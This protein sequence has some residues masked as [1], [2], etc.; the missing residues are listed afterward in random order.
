M[1]SNISSFEVEKSS[2]NKKYLIKSEA[3]DLKRRN[4]ESQHKIVFNCLGG[5]W[6]FNHRVIFKLTSKLFYDRDKWSEKE[7]LVE[8]VSEFWRRSLLTINNY[9]HFHHT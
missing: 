8:C 4:R 9:G 7:N 3:F 6:V 2:T 1:G 5:F